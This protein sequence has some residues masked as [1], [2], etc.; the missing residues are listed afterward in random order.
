MSGTMVWTP[1]GGWRFTR[2]LVCL[3]I[4]VASLGG[5][6]GARSVAAVPPAIYVDAGVTGGAG[7]GSSW[8]DAFADL[9]DALAVAAGGDEIWVAEGTYTPTTGTDRTAAFTLVPG[10]AIY[11]G[12]GGTETERSQRDWATHVVTLSGDIGIVGNSSDNS[13]HVVVGS[14]VTGTAV[15]DGFVIYGGNADGSDPDDRG[16]GIYVSDGDPTIRHCTVLGNQATFYG[17]GMA[18]EDTGAPVVVDTT[19]IDNVVTWYGGGIASLGNSP[20]QIVNVRFLHNTSSSGSGGGALSFQS[21]PAYVNTVFSG[22]AAAGDGG[23]VYNWEANAQFRNVT[24]SRNTASSR[25]GGMD[26]LGATPVVVNSIFWHNTA[27]VSG[28]QIDNSSGVANVTYSIVEGGYSGTGNLDVD[29]FFV[30][31]DGADDVV[32]TPDDDLAL[33][34]GSRAIDAGSNSAVPADVADLDGDGDAGETLPLDLGHAPRFF[35]GPQVNTGEGSSPLV[36]MGAYEKQRTC[37][38]RLNDSVTDYETVQDAVDAGAAAD[39]VVKVAGTCGGVWTRGGLTQVLIVS[40]SLTVRGGYT[41]AFTEPPDPVAHPT[42]LN[43]GGAG[44]VIVLSGAASPV[45]EGLRITGGDAAGQGGAGPDDGGGGI[46]NLNATATISNCWIFGNRAKVGGGVLLGASSELLNNEIYENAALDGGGIAT[47]MCAP[48]LTGNV[49]RHNQADGNGG[50]LNLYQTGGTLSGNTIA[51]NGADQG[52]GLYLEDSG[53][54]ITGNDILS[55]TAAASGGGLLGVDSSILLSDNEIR[56]NEADT[57]SGGGIK[58]QG[59]GTDSALVSANEIASN[60]AHWVGAG[61]LLDDSNA[62]LTGNWIHDNQGNEGSG[63]TA[64][65]SQPTVSGNTIEGNL[66]DWRGGALVYKGSAGTLSANVVRDNA[67]QSDAGAMRLEDSALTLINNAFVDNELTGDGKGALHVDASTLVLLHNTIAGN[68]GGDGYGL[69]VEPGGSVVTLT[70]TIVATQTTGVYVESGSRAGIDGV[71]WYANG[72]DTGGAGTTTV[73]SQAAGDPAFA[74]DGYH[75]TRGSAAIDSGVVTTVTT[76]IDGDARPLSSGYDIGADE[77]DGDLTAPFITSR[78]PAPGATD[79]S[80]EAALVVT[81]SEAMDTTTLDVTVVP[82]PG[83]WSQAWGAGDTT[84]TLSHA[85][86]AAETVYTVTVTAAQDV[87]GNSLVGVPVTWSFTTA[88]TEYAVYL[89]LVVRP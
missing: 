76:D 36:D 64:E 21:V 86:F 78:S 32:G 14:A 60:T 45:I 72:S 81:F 58:L 70:N 50:G 71:L 24:F 57:G 35:D 34:A 87:A 66:A 23:G 33:I 69:Y 52:G 6:F 59:E 54:E 16:G 7:D 56:G 55:N 5:A 44:R 68:S 2:I 10:V 74:L 67:A 9:Q 3:V 13:Y 28:P 43:A 40:K 17:G 62:T 30:D 84:V 11:G 19:F 47:G 89:P 46:A 8:A 29:P 49:I 39:D 12:F 22:N 61:I 80:P 31:A 18:V 53:P 1:V 25:G 79:V 27:G 73:S 82:D 38:V 65:Y 4:I 26:N 51:E 41:Q 20:T 83:A 42:T 75:L 15:L 77:Y 88:E 85:G 48:T 37:W 63:I